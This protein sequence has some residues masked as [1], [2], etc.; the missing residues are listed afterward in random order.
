MT[1]DLPAKAPA[2]FLIDIQST[3]REKLINLL[4]DAKLVSDIKT[5][6]MLRGFITKINDKKISELDLDHWSLRGDRGITYETVPTTAQ[7]VTSGKWWP[8]EYKGSPQISFAKEEGEEL[9]LSLGD[10][11][12][13]NILGRDLTG[14]ISSFRDVNFA[15]MGINFLMV[16]NPNA[17]S[18]APHT[19]IASVYAPK[20]SEGRIIK[21]ITKNFPNITSVSVRDTINKIQETITKI[22]LAIK[23]SALVIIFIGFVVILG[24]L[25]SN[26]QNR[27]FEASLLKTLGARKTLV[28]YSFGLRSAIIGSA[29]AF[30]SLVISTIMSWLIISYFLSSNYTFDFLS[31]I[32]ILLIG[33]F[34]AIVTSLLFSV[35]PL[36]SKPARILRTED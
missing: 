9:G 15:T 34:I 10:T 13:V 11:L 27:A 25:A 35:R 30:V 20:E 18:T 22:S 23:W 16:F 12:T 33:M 24:A 19:H 8:A 32:W 7:T 2:Y 1:K 36:V 14:T 29:A 26:E 3:Q 6:P 5:A 21:K 28:L 17:L 31:S 4:R